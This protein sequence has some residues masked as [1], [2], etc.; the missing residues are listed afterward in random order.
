M[1][2]RVVALAV[3]AALAVAGC[4][5]SEAPVDTGPSARELAGSLVGAGDLGTGWT[6]PWSGRTAVARG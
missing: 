1:S 5:G 2:R 6:S 3:L 4:G